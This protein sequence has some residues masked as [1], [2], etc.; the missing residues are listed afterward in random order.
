MNLA[1]QEPPPAPP[2]VGWAGHGAAWIRR[3]VRMVLK[4]LRTAAEFAYELLTGPF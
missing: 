3:K 2:S 1:R 4:A